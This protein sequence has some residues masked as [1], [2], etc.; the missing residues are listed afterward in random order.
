[1][2]NTARVKMVSGQTGWLQGVTMIRF[3][4]LARTL[5]IAL[6]VLGAAPGAQAQIREAEDLVEKTTARMLVLI[7]EAKTYVDDDPE[8][9]YVEVEGLLEPVIDFP[10][11]A[12]SVMAAHYKRATPEQR[13]RFAEGFKW[14][15]V[16][17]YALALTEFNDGGV[18]I[19]P[20]DR[21]PKRPDRA[22][23]KQEIRSEGEVYPVI[24]SMAMNSEGEWRVMNII[25][26]GINMGLTYRNQFASAVNDPVYGGD[27]DRAIDG[28]VASLGT[29]D[30]DSGGSAAPE[31]GM[32]AGDA[33]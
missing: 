12:R 11:F 15:L 23:V 4:E 8:R 16:R 24:Y 18:N 3:V 13:E 28:W 30:T 14:S 32:A 5:S 19:V 1:M 10:R 2:K 9:F 7:E 17:T 22:S 29:I 31:A 20:S 26:N 6:L 27:M 25:I 33:D 21:P